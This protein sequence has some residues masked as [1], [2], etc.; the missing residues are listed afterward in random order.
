[1][2]TWMYHKI[3]GAKI[4]DDD[5]VSNAEQ[6]GYRD[7]PTKAKAVRFIGEEP[8]PSDGEPVET[9]EVS[10]ETLEAPEVPEE[11]PE[12]PEGPEEAPEEHVATSGASDS[13]ETPEEP[14]GDILDEF[15]PGDEGAASDEE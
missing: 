15:L 1:M 13:P 3:H 11:A 4:Y 10:D 7:C 8:V 12:T 2:A 6:Y 9:P 5:Q 14:V